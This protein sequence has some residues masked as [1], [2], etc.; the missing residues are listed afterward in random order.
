MSLHGRIA[1]LLEQVASHSSLRCLEPR[2][3]SIQRVRFLELRNPLLGGASPESLLL[4]R[5]Y[6]GPRL[7]KCLVLDVTGS[8]IK[9]LV[10]YYYEPEGPLLAIS[11]ARHEHRLGR[12]R[13]A[14]QEDDKVI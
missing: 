4:T 5:A 14:R 8:T 2:V 12:S 1:V 6:A 11:I 9:L 3:R 7:E 13:P 10:R